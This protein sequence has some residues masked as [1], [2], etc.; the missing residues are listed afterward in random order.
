MIDPGEFQRF[1]DLLHANPR[2]FVPV[3]ARYLAELLLAAEVTH[4]RDPET[5]VDEIEQVAYRA[6]SRSASIVVSGTH[7]ICGY[8]PDETVGVANQRE[9]VL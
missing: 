7:T 2:S 3:P 4:W 5:G 8:E 1:L 9:G 6:K